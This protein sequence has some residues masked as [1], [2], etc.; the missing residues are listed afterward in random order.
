MCRSNCHC[1]DDTI[2]NKENQQTINHAQPI[3][4]AG[5]ERQKTKHKT[6]MLF[7]RNAVDLV[8][9][10]K[11][12]EKPVVSTESLLRTVKLHAR[13]HSSVEEVLGNINFNEG[14]LNSQKTRERVENGFNYLKNLV[15]NLK[16]GA[17]KEDYSLDKY[18]EILC[19]K[20]NVDYEAHKS[21]LKSN[22]IFKLDNSS[23]NSS[24]RSSNSVVFN[25]FIV[26]SDEG[27]IKLIPCENI[28]EQSD[29]EDLE[30]ELRSLQ[31]DEDLSAYFSE[32]TI[33]DEDDG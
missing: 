24:R 4:V 12:D 20:E 11:P 28:M 33:E 19:L 17:P 1:S 29:I 22:W 7:K 27:L 13:R 21:I 14:F 8:D 16:A 23:N 31:S 5:F 30:H 18:I 2:C 15:S 9:K 32:Y 25:D 6:T 3:P 10:N 26:P